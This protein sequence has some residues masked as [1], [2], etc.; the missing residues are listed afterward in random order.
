VANR[1]VIEPVLMKY[2]EIFHHDED[3]DF[4]SIDVIVH[5]RVTGDA[6]PVWKAPYK[7]PYVLREEVDRQVQKMMGKE[8]I[9]Q[10]HSPWQSHVACS[11]E[12]SQ[13][14]QSTGSVLIIDC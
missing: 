9:R 13:V 3:F 6:A 2:A 11:K 8:V 4:M 14:F 1:K 10:S 12:V 5:M 7:I